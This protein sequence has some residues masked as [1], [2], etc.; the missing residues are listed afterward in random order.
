LNSFELV[1]ETIAEIF[2]LLSGQEKVPE[3]VAAR[4]TAD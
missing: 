1:F 4:Q 3:V 2:A